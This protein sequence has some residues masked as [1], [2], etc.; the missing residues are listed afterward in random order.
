L[1]NSLV[2][3]HM[4]KPNSKI[5]WGIIG[6]GK[7]AH[8]FAEDIIKLPQAELYAVASR[9][10]AKAAA[11]ARQYAATKY[12]GSYHDLALDPQIDAVYIATP[13]VFHKEQSMLCLNQKKAVLCEKP[14][15]MN[16]LEVH[17]MI[18]TAQANQS[19]LMEALWT[20]FLPHYQMVLKLLAENAIGRIQ[21]LEADFGFKPDYDIASRVINKKLGGGSLLDIG[22]YPIFLA[23]TVLGMPRHIEASAT[24]FDNGTDSSCNMTFD[25]G[26]H[27]KAHLKSSFLEQTPT[28]ATIIGEKGNIKIHSRFH[29]PAAFSIEKEGNTKIIEPTVSNNG[30][31]YEI[32]HFSNLILQGQTESPV[33]TF[34]RSKQLIE[35]LDAVRERIGLYY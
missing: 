32:E 35:L 14:L 19:L 13:H 9:N 2:H 30:Y 16:S 15:A 6:L 20:Y 11:F 22:I 34:E 17:E 31:L 18:Q 21:R 3:I 25:Y 28:E 7:I 8:K 24:F 4:Y 23:L 5:H 27:A 29:G 1:I 10:E 26:D 12:Y 33:M